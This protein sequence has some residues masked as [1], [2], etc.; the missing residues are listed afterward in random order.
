MILSLKY[1]RVYIILKLRLNKVRPSFLARTIFQCSYFGLY[2][3]HFFMQMDVQEVVSTPGSTTTLVPASVSVPVDASSG[4]K[5]KALER[6][7]IGRNRTLRLLGAA[8]VRN[9]D[10]RAVTVTGGAHRHLPLTKRNVPPHQSP[11]LPPHL[12]TAIRSR[13]CYLTGGGF[14]FR[15]EKV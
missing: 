10:R 15:V 6:E 1:R 9:R 5:A 13:R 7:R 2:L 3:L 11:M 8:P 4:T 12:F 14:L